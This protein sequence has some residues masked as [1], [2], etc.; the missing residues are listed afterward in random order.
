MKPVTDGAGPMA[1]ATPVRGDE[2]LIFELSEKGHVGYRIEPLDV[3]AEPLEKLIPER[4]LRRSPLDF[5]EVTEPM[6]VRHFTRI[7]V[8]NHHIDRDVFPL[9]SC[10]MKYNPRVNETAAGLPGFAGLHPLTPEAAAQ[11]GLRLMSELSTHLAEITGM[12]R[13]SLQPAA[14]AQGEFTGLLMARAYFRA[15]GEDRTRV[16]F[17]DSAHGTN[18]ASA[19]IAGFEPV[20]IPSNE[21]GLTDVEALKRAAGSA[22]RRLHGHQSQHARIIRGGDPGDRRRSCTRPERSS[23]GR[24]QHECARRGRPA[25]RHGLRHLPPE[26][27][28]DL[29]HPARRRRSGLG[30]GGVQA[31]TRAVS[32]RGRRSASATAAF[33]LDWDRPQSVGK[34]HSFYGNFGMHVRALAYILA[35]GPDGIREC[36]RECGPERQLPEGRAC[37]ALRLPVSP[38]ARCMSSS[39]RGLAPEGGLGV[40]DCRHREAAARLRLLCA[41]RVLPADRA[42]G[43]HDRAHRVRDASAR[44]IASPKP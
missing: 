10:T 35:L 41:D 42:G 2:P 12:D 39:C 32:C 31:R 13:V 22:H 43:A 11:G 9:G 34:V 7:S 40:R 30:A 33:F 18:P 37:A 23:T 26:P 27:A 5:P 1:G 3:P 8:L 36:D 16:I 4:F 29:L 20:E 28:Q 21:R 17:P 24:R 25:R 14:G 44:S 6:V 19:A 38:A 15:K